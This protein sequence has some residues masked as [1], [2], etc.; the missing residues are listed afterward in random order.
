MVWEALILSVEALAKVFFHQPGLSLLLALTAL[1]LIHNLAVRTFK[2]KRTR[3]H[4]TILEYP[5]RTTFSIN[6]LS[7]GTH[8]YKAVMETPSKGQTT[9]G[10]ISGTN[11][12]RWFKRKWAK[13]GKQDN[14]G[15]EIGFSRWYNFHCAA[16]VFKEH[17]AFLIILRL[18][19][20]ST[21]KASGYNTVLKYRLP[22]IQTAEG[23]RDKHEEWTNGDL[24]PQTLPVFFPDFNFSCNK[25]NSWMLGRRHWIP[26]WPE[27]RKTQTI[28]N[29]K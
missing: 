29:Q 27:C 23:P 11:G 20:L 6:R 14:P 22:H 13:H 28:C 24:P 3:L 15:A 18:G 26:V 5:D 19:C 21:P 16:C 25:Y 17:W 1:S 8:V 9:S 4:T 2:R 10:L 7:K 12:S